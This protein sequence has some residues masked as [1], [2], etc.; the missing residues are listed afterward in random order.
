MT[1]PST[2]AHD[3]ARSLGHGSYAT[4]KSTARSRMGAANCRSFG[5][6]RHG[7]DDRVWHGC[8]DR[9]MIPRARTVTSTPRRSPSA[10]SSR[11]FAGV[12]ADTRM[13]ARS[14]FCDGDENRRRGRPRPENVHVV[15]AR[16]A[17]IRE[18]LHH[19]RRTSVLKPRSLATIE[20]HGVRR[21]DE[22]D[23]VRITVVRAA[24]TRRA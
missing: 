4:S 6:T 21:A 5:A 8:S 7:A 9:S 12:R 1:R 17:D 18:G 19:A 10:T 22:V 16:D 2:A 24:A 23:A 3:R 14:E 13:R 20:Q 11:A 15:E